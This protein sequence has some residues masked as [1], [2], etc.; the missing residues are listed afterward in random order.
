MLRLAVAERPG[1]EVC[2]A[3]IERAGTSY[4]IETLDHLRRSGLL[5]LFVL[6]ADS[7]VEIPTWRSYRRLLDEYD[8][9]AVERPGSSIG[10]LPRGPG[11]E[12]GSRIV[13][14]PCVEGAGLRAATEPPGSGGRIFHVPIPQ[15]GVSSSR[16]RELAS[17]R[18]PLDGLVPSSVAR[19]IQEQGLYGKEA[20]R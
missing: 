15:V 17:A 16:I 14:V 1:L 6:G 19:Y 18:A 3:E 4:T 11:G 2:H 9:V 12:I 20:N 8:L 7:L 10:V 5:P 13:A